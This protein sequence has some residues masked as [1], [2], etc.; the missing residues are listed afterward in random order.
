[1]RVYKNNGNRDEN[2]HK[3]HVKSR[4]AIYNYVD[5]I[6]YVNLFMI[7]SVSLILIFNFK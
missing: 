7:S 6:E 1:M 3:L 2:T 5:R 4:H